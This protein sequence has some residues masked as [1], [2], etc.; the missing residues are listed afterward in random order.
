[1]NTNPAIHKLFYLVFMIIV[2]ACQTIMPV[3]TA[4]PLVEP[5]QT[6]TPIPITTPTPILPPTEVPAPLGELSFSDRPDDHPDKYQIHVL[7][8]VPMDFYDTKRY[9][10][11]SI[12]E[13]MKLMNEWFADQ[14]DG[15]SFILDTYQG[16]LDITYI[17]LPA[18]EDEIAEYAKNEHRKYDLEFDGIQYLHYAI[19]DYIYQMEDLPFEP[20]KL[21]VAYV[22]FSLAYTCSDAQSGKGYLV[23]KVF[24]SAY[25]L[26]HK[27]NCSYFSSQ[28]L[29][30]KY[31]VWESITA[32]ETIHLLAIP[33]A[34][35]PSNGID[36]NYHIEDPE[37]PDDIMG[38]G[39]YSENPVLDPNHDDYYLTDK[40]CL[41][42]ADTPYL[43]S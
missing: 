28:S 5:A 27:V 19:E 29:D 40:P 16:S 9:F 41:D 37:T 31:G 14:T 30:D 24:P 10:D 34:S 35:C 20:R 18:T 22:E 12:D 39:M 17:Q 8:V 15:R 43:Y 21:Y 6:N 1:L 36:A 33:A 4:T 38:A 42:L 32:H 25:S 11:G 7:Y 3:P 26:Y 2:S 13:N 23:A